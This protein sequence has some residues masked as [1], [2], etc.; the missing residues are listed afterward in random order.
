MF[1]FLL[2]IEL[3]MLRV[4]VGVVI[5]MGVFFEMIII[6]DDHVHVHMNTGIV[7][8]VGTTQ[9]DGVVDGLEIAVDVGGQCIRLIHILA[10][11]TRTPIFVIQLAPHS[12]SRVASSK[13][14][15]SKAIVVVAMLELG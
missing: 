9:H 8:G 13:G 10:M 12:C 5:G 4:G 3:S 6:G 14:D 15:D 2:W 11:T 7:G 1:V